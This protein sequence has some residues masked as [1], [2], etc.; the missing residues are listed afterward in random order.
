M[1]LGYYPDG[2]P[3]RPPRTVFIVGSQPRHLYYL[4]RIQ[5]HVNCAGIIVQQRGELMPALPANLAPRDRKHWQKH[6][7]NRFDAE[8]AYFGK[9]QP[10]LKG[11]LETSR[12]NSVESAEY[13]E[14]RQPQLVLIFG[15]GMIRDP[16]MSA[17]PVD[18]LNLHLGLSPRYRGA[19]TLFW[20]YYFLEPNH[21]GATFHRIVREPDAGEILHQCRPK[22]SPRDNMQETAAKAVVTATN[23]MVAL[24]QRLKCGGGW[25]FHRQKNTGKVFMVSDFQPQHLRP[26]YEIWGDHINEAF[27]AGDLKV[28]EPFVYAANLAQPEKRED[29]LAW[30]GEGI[31]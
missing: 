10:N 24:L 18:S 13:V 31:A 8:M 20:P 21:A 1:A 2:E 19:A 25:S 14:E 11:A 29:A 4:A 22:L 23:D 3:I 5:P 26:I 30:N 7:G 28:K 9:A 16:L 6:F 15:T 12:L 17:L 27:L